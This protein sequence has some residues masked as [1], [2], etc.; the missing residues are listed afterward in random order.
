MFNEK[1]E[2]SWGSAKYLEICRKW[3]TKKKL[4]KYII[5][6]SNNAK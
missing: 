3:S 2:S 6:R 4:K 5:N 1:S